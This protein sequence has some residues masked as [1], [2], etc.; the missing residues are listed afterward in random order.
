[1]PLIRTEIKGQPIRCFILP[2]TP[3]HPRW[4]HFAARWREFATSDSV[5]GLDVETTAIDE[6]LGTFD[7]AMR[8]RAVQFGTE[9]EGWL[10]DPTSPVWRRRIVGLLAD[11]SKRFVSHTNYD[12]LWTL[13]EFGI[14]LP[15]E[16]RS[17]DT[18]PMASL[19]RP[20]PLRPKDLKTL[21]E[22][23]IDGQLV[24]AEAAMDARFFELAPKEARIG[25]TSKNGLKAGKRLKAWGFTHIPLD[26]PAF[27]LYGALD[28][29]YVR[30][31]LPILDALLKQ[32][33][34]AKLSKREQKI[35]RLMT[36]TQVRGMLVDAEFTKAALDEVE[37]KFYA[38]DGRLR[39]VLGFTPGSPRVG[40]WLE[41]HGVVFYERTPTGRPKL[42][43]DTIPI[44]AENADPMTE[45]GAVLHDLAV[46]SS[47]KNL[48]TNLATCYRARDAHGFVH[49]RIKTQQA[50]TGR[51]SITGPAMQTF[52]K[53]PLRGCFIARPG[54]LFVGADYDS[55]EIR[56]A[57]AFS[58][59]P[60][61]VK[62]ISEGLNQHDLTA[63][64]I[65][66]PDWRDNPRNRQYAKVL[67]FAQQYGAGPKA[68]AFQLGI[69]VKEAAKLW[70]AWNKAYSTL[71]SWSK[72][73]ARYD[74]VTNPWERL[75]PADKWRP[76][77]N[78]NYAI[79]SSGRD[80]LGDALVRLNE[81]GYGQTIWLPI[82]DEIILEVPEDGAERAAAVLSEAM[83]TTVGDIELTATAAIIG[84]RWS[85]A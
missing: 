27:G 48:K 5:F 76:Y 66:G 70:K 50:V 14:D 4:P 45:A 8:L 62:I 19:L 82:H 31:L 43:K 84:T 30:R 32:K 85:G 68:I 47:S 59:D 77:A 65:F 36:G 12:A 6:D 44:L 2:P 15:A 56:L 24:A 1:M 60:A 7:P 38:A 81:M 13:R 11:P 25:T 80:A 74:S 18:M 23:Y 33:G 61:Y 75:I 16:D 49:P 54:H 39:E 37:T 63:E 40:P 29:I 71:V 73:L 26:D 57:A 20:G 83:F 79:Q 35:E 42:D 55:Q 34:M 78:G 58:G 64:L 72:E 46:L 22:L 67:N 9:T 53:G 52:K 3:G 10:L 51:M 69:S 17:I 41:G 21:S 28:A